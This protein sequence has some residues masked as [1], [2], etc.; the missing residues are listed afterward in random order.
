MTS[1]L[2]IMIGMQCLQLVVSFYTLLQMRE[3]E[4]RKLAQN[5]IT[6]LEEKKGMPAE[7][8]QKIAEG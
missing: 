8:R 6:H 7:R 5:I 1:I 2:I 3:M 4:E